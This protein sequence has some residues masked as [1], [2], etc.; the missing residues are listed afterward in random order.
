LLN[1]TDL[2]LWPRF[3]QAEKAML[4]SLR[5]DGEDEEQQTFQKTNATQVFRK[6]ERRF[7][8]TAIDRIDFF[9]NEDVLRA[10]Q[11]ASHGQLQEMHVKATLKHARRQS[12]DAA[13]NRYAG[14]DSDRLETVDGRNLAEEVEDEVA[15][16]LDPE[17]FAFL[18]DIQWYK[19]GGKEHS[20]FER[21]STY[22]HMVIDEAQEMSPV[23]LNVLGRALT[24]DATVTLAG[25]AA[26]QTDPSTTFASW[27]SIL[28][29][30]GVPPIQA[31][32]LKTSYRSTK[33]IIQFAHDI[34]GNPNIPLP[35]AVRDGVPVGQ[36]I[37]PTDGH[38]AIFMTDVLTQLMVNEPH[39]S[40]AVVAKDSTYAESVFH[41]LSA[42]PKL[43]L[44]LEG[45]FDFKPGV[46]V[47]DV[48]Q[49]KGLEF[50][51]VIVPDCSAGRYQDTPIDRRLLHVAATRAIHQLWVISVGAPSII[52]ADVQN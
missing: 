35:R 29:Q 38:A 50:D 19:T 39:A 48:T 1:R 23:E 4:K 51:Y 17:D 26:Q 9:G 13:A 8:H 24:D 15:G 47:T 46:D 37:L 41:A 33:P 45:N 43:K 11:Q 25:D 20:A 2:A 12:E 22:A 27:E 6:L 52:L 14:I 32:H 44:V 18:I 3:K 49:V 16:S 40:V 28:Q 34:L 10:V 21:R 5:R 30:L 31:Q 36:S 7:F 42:V